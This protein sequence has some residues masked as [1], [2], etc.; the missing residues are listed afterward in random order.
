M[1][2]K[3]PD[4][5]WVQSPNYSSRS[6]KS[7]RLIVVH[8]CEGSETGAISWFTQPRSRVSAHAV[9]SADGKRL[10]RM[11]D[12]QNKAW[13]ACN[14]NPVSEGIE[15]AGFEAKGFDAVE[16]QALANV[17]AWRLKA[18]GLPPVWAKGGN[19]P[20]FCSHR[21]LGAAGGGH[22]DPTTDNEIWA[23]FVSLVQTVYVGAHGES[24]SPVITIPPPPAP[25]GWTPHGT[26]RHDH[27]AGSFEWAQ[28][29]LNALGFAR[30]LL[31]VDGMNGP[32]TTRAVVAFQSAHGLYVDG[33][34]G[35]A[36]AA[37]MVTLA[38]AQ[39][40]HP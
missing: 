22:M 20:G 19:G 31:M 32:A 38:T 18:R 24:V 36:T 27:D 3:L 15:M 39:A 30:P 2:F 4:M 11:V 5:A 14:F 28:L 8:D 21:D 16:W 33:V 1:T 40:T 23:N 26:V 17:T 25:A 29:E 10:T 9:L 34:Y 7:V 35:P 37:A 13:H 12:W 6:G